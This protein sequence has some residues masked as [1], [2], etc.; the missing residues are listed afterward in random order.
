MASIVLRMLA[1]TSMS[2]YQNEFTDVTTAHWAAN[3]IQTAKEAS[4]ISGMGDGTFLPDGEVTYAQVIVMLVNALNYKNDA[5][6]Y[7]GWQQGYIKVAGSSELDLLKNASGSNDV[8]ADRGLV[9]KMVYNALFADYKQITGYENGGP[10]YEVKKNEENL[11]NAKFDIIDEKGVL[12]ATSKTS[13]DPTISVQA[14]EVAIKKNGSDKAETYLTSLTDIEDML[15]QKVIYYYKDINGKTPEVYAIVPDTSKST[16]EEYD[17]DDIESITGFD[18]GNPQIKIDGVSKKKSFADDVNIIYNGDTITEAD[19]IDAKAKATTAGEKVR[20]GGEDGTFNDFLNPEYGK[21]KMVDADND[22]KFETLFVDSYET[23][24]VSSATADRLV[25]NIYDP[26]SDS[27]ISLSLKLDT[28]D[29]DVTVTVKKAGTDV[30][31]RNLKKNDVASM[32]RSIDNK[33]VDIV[34]TGENVTGEAS[35]FSAKIDNAYVKVNGTKYDVANIAIG[36][37]KTG[38]QSTFFF[39]MFGRIAYVES[40]TAGRLGSGEQYAW[41]INGYDS[42]DGQNYLVQLFTQD[43]KA[44]E[45]KFAENVSL[46]LPNADITSMKKTDAADAVKS[47]IDNAKYLKTSDSKQIRLVKFKANANNAIT[48]IY[49]AQESTKALEDSDALIVNT[50]NLKS[51]ATVGGAVNGYQIADGIMEF[52]VPETVADMADSSNYKVGTVT[53]SVY[54]VRENGSTRNYIVGEFEDSTNVNI[55]V[56]FTASANDAAVMTDM[57][58]SGSGPMAMVVDEIAKGVDDDD[59]VVYT[60]SGYMGGADVSITTNKN[61]NV[62]MLTAALWTDSNNGRNYDAPTVWD[63]TG[64]TYKDV[65][66]STVIKQGDLILYT[67]DGRLVAKFADGKD[68]YNKI[69]NGKAYAHP[70]GALPNKSGSRC[71]Y[72][73]SKLTDS[74][75]SDIAYIKIEDYAN[76]IIFDPSKLMDVV[77]ININTGDVDIDLDGATVSDLITYDEASKTGDFI[78]VSTANKGDINSIVVYRFED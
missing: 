9:I 70:F 57:D 6:Y 20:F 76:N 44:N 35:G 17:A 27:K 38:S 39:D 52:N 3:Q 48:E 8:A 2:T 65:D 58:S 74:G 32:K 7:G 55:I 28:D 71:A 60:I 42:E 53:A 23:L 22:D 45:Y 13:S 41:I 50:Q 54:A 62:G 49:F 15:A 47:V 46:W 67:S 11:A 34:V 36:D 12:V 10:K 64:K 56:N 29:E 1:I 14:G 24:I 63:G 19:Y 33:V 43:G 73:F 26:E 61:T 66:L 4:I 25:G 37:I 21:I 72:Y 68:L 40:S 31:L 30:K 18:G 51:V 77:T 69:V 78:Y 59:N 75:L 16:T 5:M